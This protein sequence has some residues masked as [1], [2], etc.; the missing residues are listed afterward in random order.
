MREPN[1]GVLHV[2][3]GQKPEQSQTSFV[4]PFY[5]RVWREIAKLNLGNAEAETTKKKNHAGGPRGGG[6][7][8]AEGKTS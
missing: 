8:L 5:L 1:S 7:P 2:Q 6:S 4:V 3:S